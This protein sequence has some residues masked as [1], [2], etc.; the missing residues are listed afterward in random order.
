MRCKNCGF[1]NSENLYICQ[2]CGSPLYDDDELEEVSESEGVGGTRVFEPI[3]SGETSNAMRNTRERRIER[4]A[5]KKKKQQQKT[6]II[7]ILAMVL[8][9]VVAGVVA[10]LANGNSKPEVSTDIITTEQTEPTSISTT[11]QSTAKPT[12]EATTEPKTTES[13]T[14]ETTTT[15]PVTYKLSLS[16]NDGGE[17]EGS[18][19]Y[20]L[21]ENVTIIARADDGYEF[22]GWYKGSTKISGNTM[23]T[24]TI[25]ESTNLKA[26]FTPIQD[27]TEPTTEGIDVLEGEDN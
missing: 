3:Y 22:I 20:Q 2:N 15:K 19:N 27:E 6:A 5:E 7:I 24:V 14:E 18:G 12:T 17:T 26:V 8:I 1:D 25:T 16:S 9:A 13:T 21:G 4:E 10:A 23:Y 11:Q